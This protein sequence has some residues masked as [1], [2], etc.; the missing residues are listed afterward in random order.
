MPPIL[1]D[2]E[3]DVIDESSL[4]RVRLFEVLSA[5]GGISAVDVV[6]LVVDRINEND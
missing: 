1:G 4:R 3:V 5:A 2:F 6:G